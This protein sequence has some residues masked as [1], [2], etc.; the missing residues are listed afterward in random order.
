MRIFRSFFRRKRIAAQMQE[1]M[2]FHVQ[3]RMDDLVASG[4]DPREAARTAR[5]EFG[6]VPAYR[7]ESRA[8]IG[9]RLWDEL[10]SDLR[11]AARG[12][13]QSPGFAAA[14][15]AILTLAIG[16]NGA[17]FTLYSNYVLRPLP[18]RGVDRH[19]AIEGYGQNARANARFT[20]SEIDAFEQGATAELEGV[21]SAGT[22]QVLVVAPTQR[23]SLVTTVSGSYFRLLGGNPALGRTLTGADQREPVAV[24]SD[25]GHRRYFPSI[26]PVGQRIQVR[27]TLF[28]VVGVM[29]PGFTGIE[30]VVPDF[31]VSNGMRNA[32]RGDALDGEPRY[33]LFAML[34][35]GIAPARAEA[36]IS[37]I[38][39]R[40]AR[41]DAERIARLYLK[42]Q[43]TYLLD[44]AELTAV[45]YIV[46]AAFWMV[47]LI[48]CANLANLYLSRAASR[49][50]EIA[51]RLSLGA[52]RVRIIRQLLT[53]S[54][55]TASLGAAF[56]CMLATLAVNYAYRYAVS[57]SGVGGLVMLPLVFDWRILLYSAALGGAAGIL[58][59]LLPAVEITSPSLTQSTK[60][61]QSAFAGR[62]RPRRLRDL[63]IA[64][65]VA[66]SLVLLIVG[67]LLIRN[68]QRLNGV[69]PGYDLQRVF[70]LR[71]DQPGAALL[72]NIEHLPGVTSVS[73]VARV[74]LYGGLPTQPALVDNRSILLAAN[75]VDQAYFATLAL[76]VE[77]RNFTIAETRNA[78]KVAVISRKTAAL[79]WPAG[80]SPIGRTLS[81][82]EPAVAYQVIGVVPDVISGWFWQ[83]KDRSAVYLPGAAGYNESVR[84]AIVR[85]D[86]A[87][88]NEVTAA[89]RRL[90]TDATGC[91]PAPLH[92]ISALQRFPFRVAAAVAGV[93]GGLA[94]LLTAVGLY[95]VA[96]FSVLQRRREI[97]VHLALGATPLQVTRRILGEAWRC[98]GIGFA[99]G[100]PFCLLLSQLASRLVVEIRTFDPGAY[101]AV[102]ILLAVTAT[103]ACAGPARRAARL[104]PMHSL[105]EE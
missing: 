91:E 86:S 46:F 57:T 18:V 9:Y 32:L 88:P 77:G 21:Y 74:P 66:A 12:L 62:L 22:I 7:E 55:F 30:P 53:E 50:H 103:I 5:L 8:A 13:R 87:N 25:S 16:A 72:A 70:D 52:S 92:E 27:G 48:A 39:T 100:L 73:S 68:L 75:V 99:L 56:G 47:L 84:S 40:F 89:I 38:A 63:L 35:P 98:V 17:F 102:P 10:R 60:R 90:C 6:S 71:A 24:L 3:A 37:A 34:R 54:V 104:D 58:F 82:G 79:L 23:Q 31:W 19:Y 83:G 36:A 1:E 95:A 44:E 20:L 11:F 76:P 97:G 33:A 80:G 28:T 85:I 2:E 78:A 64:G 15:I 101:L 29:P 96:N 59:G 42:P 14:A 26:N 51:M 45:A 43:R 67:G 41:P 105:R 69:D 65:Q 61:E 94:L 93:L 4:M 49:T 81:L